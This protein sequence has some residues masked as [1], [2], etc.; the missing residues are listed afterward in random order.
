M[1]FLANENFPLASIQLLRQA[2]HNVV[3]IMQE[4]PGSK[5]LDILVR[6]HAEKL[7]ILTFDRDYGEMIYRHKAA[8]PAGVVYL[9]FAP[10]TPTEPGEILLKIIDKVSLSLIDRFTIVERG[11]IRQRTLHAVK[12]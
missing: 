1:D 6:A 2:G 11:R 5:D 9:R 10:F 8:P 4:A 7:V 12:G 3:S